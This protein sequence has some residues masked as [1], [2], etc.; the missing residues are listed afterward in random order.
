MPNRSEQEEFFESMS[1]WI[2]EKYESF[3]VDNFIIALTVG[4]KAH[5]FYNI[6]DEYFLQY[7]AFMLLKSFYK[8]TDLVEFKNHFRILKRIAAAI[9]LSESENEEEENEIVPEKG[10]A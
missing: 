9:E 6:A 3:G 8:N 7:T 10:T 5:F 2:S 4:E 1:K